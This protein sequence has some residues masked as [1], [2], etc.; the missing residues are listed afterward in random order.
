MTISNNNIQMY[1]T[2]LDP[3]SPEQL[4]YS[5]S[6]GGYVSSSYLYPKTTFLQSSGLYDTTLYL[7]TPS[8]GWSSWEESEYLTA[9]GEIL[10]ITGNANAET[11]VDTRGF[12]RLVR[13][14][15]A[16]DDI[17]AIKDN[18]FNDVF[19]ADYK[20]RR[21]IAIVNNSLTD[22]AYNVYV[23]VNQIGFNPHM[24][25]RMAIEKPISQYL[26]ARTSSSI[27]SDRMSLTDNSLTGYDDNY[28][29]DAYLRIGNTGRTIGSF[30]SDPETG[31]GVFTF[32]EALPYG[33]SQNSSYTIDAGPCQRLRSGLDDTLDNNRISE[34]ALATN[35]TSMSINILNEVN[36]GTLAPKNVIYVWVE[37]FVKKGTESLE[38]NSIVLNIKYNLTGS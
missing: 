4:I 6:V 12:N 16:G 9:N 21:C 20:Q 30:E 38:N 34:Y 24:E 18:F 14:H 29:Q 32:L 35:Q 25:L 23:G 7:N 22:S 37:R 36:G 13:I 28:F 15:L 33:T 31:Y 19:N 1:L 26:P 10:K 5:Q 11:T 2:C 8:E 27:S 3:S 17:Y